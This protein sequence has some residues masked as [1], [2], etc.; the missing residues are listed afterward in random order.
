MGVTVGDYDNDGWPDLF[1]TGVGGNRLFHNE[2]VKE[3]DP[4]KGRR[5]RDVTATA[6]VGGPGGWPDKLP[7]D[8]LKYD[9]PLCWSTSAAFLDFDGDGLLDLFVCNYVTWSPD[10]DIKL[11]FKLVGHGRAYG[12]P[13]EFEG[14]QCFLYRNRGDGTFEDVSAKAGIQVFEKEGTEEGARLRNVG[15]SLGVIVCDVDDDGW[16]DIV[17]G[18]DTVRNFFFHNVPGPDGT[19]RF[20][21]KGHFS[22]VAYAEGKARG[23][24]GVDWAPDY[25]P[26]LSA[27]AIGNFANEPDTFLCLEDPR[28]LQF[29]DM[30][31]AEGIAGPSRELLKFGLFFFD[32]DLDG[33]L[34]LLTCNGHLEPEITKVQASQHYEQPVQLFWNTGQ[35]PRGFEPVTP[36]K[37]GSDLFRPLV[38]R[39]CAFLDMDGD[40]HLDV[41]LVANGGE[42]RLLHNEGKTGHH[43]VRL[44]LQG[45]GKRSNRSAI[46]ARVRLEAGG[47]VQR[48]EVVSGRG[49][50]SQSELVLTFGLGTV[51]KID[52]VTIQWP[53]ANP[54]PPLVLENLGIDTEHVITQK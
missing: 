13:T 26:G 48:G 7:G 15:K 27:L 8:F 31:L 11:G 22:G 46:G 9:K 6:G 17:V 30:A 40:G 35:Q 38:G 45:D 12:R 50:L 28:R 43:W 41:V 42:A 14:A 23:A 36:E 19:R 5:F 2:P 33:R 3:G 37:A 39:G 32:Y 54:G 4:T 1:I 34:D 16:P 10:D 18:N 29:S 24:M 53:G 21:E 51:T 52:R 49:Y 44:K 20:V 25:R 47:K